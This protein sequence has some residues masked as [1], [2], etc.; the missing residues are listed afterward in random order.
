[1]HHLQVPFPFPILFHLNPNPS[2]LAQSSHSFLRL[3]FQPPQAVDRTSHLHLPHL[4]LPYLHLL[5]TLSTTPLHAHFAPTPT[6]NP[7]CLP[8][9]HPL[10]SPN[11]P[12][13]TTPPPPLTKTTPPIPPKTTPPILPK[14]A[15]PIT[16][17]A[18]PAHIRK[19]A[20]SPRTT[21]TPRRLFQPCARLGV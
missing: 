21:A 10:S 9:P 19:T 4:H 15:P 17:K 13:S 7:L 18:T 5:A 1:M 12:Q 2:Q 14:T 8:L 11:P 3:D 6:F 16:R 20:P